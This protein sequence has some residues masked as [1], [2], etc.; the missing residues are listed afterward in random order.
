LPRERTPKE[1]LEHG[2][3]LVTFS[4]DKLLGGVQA[5]IVVGRRAEI[6]RLRA[7]P[8]K[9]ALRCDKITLAMLRETLRLHQDPETAVREIPLLQALTKPLATVEAAAR[10]IA[11]HVARLLAEPFA[12]SV[13]ESRCQIG[14]GAL[15][16]AAVAS[17]AVRI[18]SAHDGDVRALAERMRRLP[19]PVLGRIHEGAL[20][21][22]VRAVSDLD[23]LERTL[24]DLGPVA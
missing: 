6:E 20:W 24:A 15:P 21:L 17:F 22:D 23:R 19:T 13:A 12:V 11:A 18:A 4:G 3:D 10:R 2:A 8:L 9:R 14:S 1:A 16:D 5:G 7:N